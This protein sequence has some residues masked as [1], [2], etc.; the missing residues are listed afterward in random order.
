[1]SSATVALNPA[2]LINAA[3]TS[4]TYAAAYP[5]SSEFVTI[6]ANYLPLAVGAGSSVGVTTGNWLSPSTPN[7]ATANIQASG[8]YAINPT[9]PLNPA[10]PFNSFSLYNPAGTGTLGVIN[11]PSEY[12][13][14]GLQGIGT[15]L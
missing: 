8:A 6:A 14:L 2:T 15:T 9:T 12:P 4:G 3:N 10:T 7:N 13:N 1:M 5:N 11:G